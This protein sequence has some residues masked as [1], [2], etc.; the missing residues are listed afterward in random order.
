MCCLVLTC[1]VT[2]QSGSVAPMLSDQEVAEGNRLIEDLNALKS[3]P[4]GSGM[5]V[6]CCTEISVALLFYLL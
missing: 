6:L 5:Y 1:S 4:L 3:K 2:E